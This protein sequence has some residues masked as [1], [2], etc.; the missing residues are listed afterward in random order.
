MIIYKFTSK[1]MNLIYLKIKLRIM[2]LF[3]HSLFSYVVMSN[4]E[5]TASSYDVPFPTRSVPERMD[6]PLRSSMDNYPLVI[7]RKRLT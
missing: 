2:R 5:G 7:K 3:V 1:Y 6:G 4:Q